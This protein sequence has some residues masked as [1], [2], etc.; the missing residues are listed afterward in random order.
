MFLTRPHPDGSAPRDGGFTLIEVLTAVALSALL[1]VPI[2]MGISIVFKT[3][4]ISTESVAQSHDLQQAVNYLPADART[5]SFDPQGYK[6]SADEDRGSG[7]SDEGNEN[8]LRIDDGSENIQRRIAYRL[9]AQPNGTASL[10]RYECHVDGT[11]LGVTNIADSLVADGAEPAAASDLV[12]V[13]DSEGN[14]TVDRV[15]L[16][17]A[18]NNGVETISA[19]PLAEPEIPAVAAPTGESAVCGNDLLAATQKFST[20]TEL[21]VHLR[22]GDTK[23]ST[24]VGGKLSWEGLATLGQNFQSGEY[25]TINPGQTV[26]YI[27]R[28]DWANSSGEL[29]IPGG[30]ADVVVADMTDTTISAD[31]R[32]IYGPA[33]PSS[34]F[35]N[36]QN[37]RAGT[38]QTIVDF[39]DAFETL[40]ACS[41]AMA[42][43]PNSC[44]ACAE[45]VELRDQNGSAP[46][47]GVGNPGGANQVKIALH[48]TKANVLNLTAAQLNGI[49]DPVFMWK[50]GTGASGAPVPG[51]TNPLIINV[52]DSGDIVLN[53]IARTQQGPQ[54][55][56]YNF[57]NATSVRVEG[58]VVWG[59][60]FAPQAFVSVRQQMQG[61]VI[62][63]SWENGGAEVNTSRLFSGW[64]DWSA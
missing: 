15:E 21:D 23:R 45:H 61:G 47:P 54:H 4:R 5:G 24:A 16:R 46:Y 43:L 36:V 20:F 2:T 31:G 58:E 30:H 48:P 52:M 50:S 19:A 18:Q 32:K 14:V 25:P 7:C 63:Q 33:G 38:A 27:Q 13:E 53:S 28:I 49:G 62:A 35:V 57:P 51:R 1:I 17:L 34:T 11:V 9:V 59:T 56:L 55:I 29:R 40:R 3:S 41:Q 22:R 60:I 6:T 26:L 12:L 39:T 64:I 44:T 10:D 8:V 42:S 37:G